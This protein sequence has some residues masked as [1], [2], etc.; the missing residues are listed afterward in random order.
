MRHGI[1]ESIV[2]KESEAPRKPPSLDKKKLD[3]KK[4]DILEA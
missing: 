1:K 4:K 2:G 3:E